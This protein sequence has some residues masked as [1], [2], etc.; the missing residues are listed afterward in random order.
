MT[1]LGPAETEGKDTLRGK[2][3]VVKGG[4]DD[5]YLMLLIYIL[6]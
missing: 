4:E 3:R 5:F 2:G 6:F 1:V